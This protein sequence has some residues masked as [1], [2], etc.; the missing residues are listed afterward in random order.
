MLR[1]AERTRL[2]TSFFVFVSGLENSMKNVIIE[3][4]KKTA[5]ELVCRLIN[6]CTHF[7]YTS[8]QAISN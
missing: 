7:R 1:C 6:D 3:N 4:V 5:V 8:Q 2:A